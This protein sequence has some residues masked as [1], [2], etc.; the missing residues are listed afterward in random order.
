MLYD[1]TTYAE[2]SLT[3]DG[4]GVG[5]LHPSTV[6]GLVGGVPACRVQGEGDGLFHSSA[7]RLGIHNRQHVVNQSKREGR[8]RR[9]IERQRERDR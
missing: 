1:I 3:G 8:W 9:G 2:I 4:G 7:L 6:G 5:S